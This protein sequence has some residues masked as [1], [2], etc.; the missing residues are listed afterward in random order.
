MKIL[1]ILTAVIFW[2]TMETWAAFIGLA[3]F[4]TA[5]L[6]NE[7]D[8]EKQRKK[9]IVEKFFAENPDKDYCKVIHEG[10]PYVISRKTIKNDLKK[11]Q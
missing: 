2:S 6:L 1:L 10:K 3:F 4:V 5:I 11:L 9:H 8:E 7:K